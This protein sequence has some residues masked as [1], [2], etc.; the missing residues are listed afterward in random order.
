MTFRAGEWDPS[1]ARTGH[2][3]KASDA[4]ANTDGFLTSIP[5]VPSLL[6]A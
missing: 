6:A 3:G 4:E 2:E 5:T 1:R